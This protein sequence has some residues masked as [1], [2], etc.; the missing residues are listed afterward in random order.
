MRLIRLMPINQNPHTSGPAKISKTY[1]TSSM[2]F[3]WMI[4]TESFFRDY[5]A[6]NAVLADIQYI[7][8]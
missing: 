6:Q 3:G 7:G 1:P 4:R 5:A 8:S 2:A